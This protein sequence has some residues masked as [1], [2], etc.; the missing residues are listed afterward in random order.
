MTDVSQLKFL[1]I[2]LP[3][4]VTPPENPAFV[5][6]K[7]PREAGRWSRAKHPPHLTFFEFKVHPSLLDRATKWFLDHSVEIEGICSQLVFDTWHIFY[8]KKFHVAVLAPSSDTP[9]LGGAI[10]QR[11]RLLLQLF[12]DFDCNDKPVAS[13][14]DGFPIW[15]LYD[16]HGQL[17]FSTSLYHRPEIWDP[18]ITIAMK[19]RNLEEKY[20]EGLF[21]ESRVAVIETEKLWYQVLEKD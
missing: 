15:L 20:D 10:S 3:A 1:Q 9:W 13:E 8:K 11:E 5:S 7:P 16:T 12:R 14:K 21:K 17:C 6:K 18:H 19:F 2:K 4:I